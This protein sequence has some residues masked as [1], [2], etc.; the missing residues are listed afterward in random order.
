M[1][2][3]WTSRM[4]VRL[5]GVRAGWGGIYPAQKRKGTRPLQTSM[6][7]VCPQPFALMDAVMAPCP[8]STVEAQPG[9]PSGCHGT[10][11]TCRRQTLGTVSSGAAG[12]P[13]PV[14]PSSGAQAGRACRSLLSS[15]GDDGSG[16]GS[17]GGCPDD[18]CGRRV[19]KKSSSSRTPLTHAL[20]GLSEQEGQKTSAASCPEPHSFFL[21]FLVTLVLAAARPRW[22]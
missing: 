21:L 18:T 6:P 17:G 12:L 7:G 2:M 10:G 3:M 22:R 5:A 14:S 11:G 9:C 1:A 4:P 8:C 13:L 19:S 16:S 15:S 20:P